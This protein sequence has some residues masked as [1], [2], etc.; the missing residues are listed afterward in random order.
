MPIYEYRCENC[1][2]E[3]EVFQHY[4][5]PA[6]KK[7]PECKKMKL[8]RLISEPLHVSVK[9]DPKTLGH[10][11]HRNREEMSTWEYEAKM[12]KLK[13]EQPALPSGMKRGQLQKKEAFWRNGPPKK[14]LATATP[15][16]IK[17]YVEKGQVP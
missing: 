7:C 13:P 10:L 9:N 5:D 15:K 11:A 14:S 2:E 16:Q 17:D 12:E 1:R 4:N 8:E 3:F 6:K